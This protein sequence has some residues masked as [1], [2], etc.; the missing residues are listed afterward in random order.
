MMKF[1]SLSILLSSVSLIQVSSAA[2]VWTG[3]GDGVSLFQEANWLDDSDNSVPPAGTIDPGSGISSSFGSIIMA[4]DNTTYGPFNGNFDL[5]GNTLE[6]SGT[7]G[8]LLA[9]GS[10]LRSNGGGAISTVNAAGISTID[11]QFTQQL[12]I[13]LTGAAD[14][15]YQGGGNPL[16][17]TLIDLA[18]DWTGQIITVNETV[19][20]WS[21]PSSAAGTLRGVAN[22]PHIDKIT[23]A[24]Q[25]AV[26]GENV[27][28]VSDGASGAILTVI[29]EPSTSL[30]AVL[31]MFV[32]ARRKR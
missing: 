3:A 10:G 28:L 27:Q 21:D 13:N 5:G 9:N 30:L 8:T 24:G 20:D 26:I 12:D 23:V 18:A 25:P 4:A 22:V 17:D 19:A 2:L 29:P 7:N 6:L 32:V 14:L 31:G 11:V 1:T 16:N 15:I